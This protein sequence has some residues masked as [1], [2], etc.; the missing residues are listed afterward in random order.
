MVTA[1]NNL[2]ARRGDRVILATSRR[3]VLGGA[4]LLYI[5]PVVALIAGGATGERLGPGWGLAPTLAA[6]ILGL[7]AL[8]LSGAFLRL[9]SKRMERSQALQVRIVKVIGGNA[10]AGD[11]AGCRGV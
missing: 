9:V 1:L 8:V 3:N 5:L 4:F 2:G 6:I 10:G 11:R 7:A